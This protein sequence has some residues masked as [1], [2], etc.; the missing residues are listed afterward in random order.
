MN[1]LLQQVK[2]IHVGAANQGKR[3]HETMSPT[4]FDC[5]DVNC[6]NT[7]RGGQSV[8]YVT[9][10]CTRN[11]YNTPGTYCWRA[12]TKVMV[13]SLHMFNLGLRLGWDQVL[14]L[15]LVLGIGFG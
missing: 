14:E 6:G 3:I 9:C 7:C 5:R 8:A 1:S 10:S 13:V 12:G 2:D 15:G 11:G 4:R